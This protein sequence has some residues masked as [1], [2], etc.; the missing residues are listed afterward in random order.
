M[1]RQCESESYTEGIIGRKFSRQ[2]IGRS[3]AK[4]PFLSPCFPHRYANCSAIEMQKILPSP[5]FLFFVPFS[6]PPNQITNSYRRTPQPCIIY[7]STSL[8]QCYRK[9]MEV[10]QCSLTRYKKDC[11]ICKE[12]TMF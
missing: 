1:Q 7:L 12:N 4:L 8:C 6:L 11:P 2:G 5:P 10:L 3:R 9:E